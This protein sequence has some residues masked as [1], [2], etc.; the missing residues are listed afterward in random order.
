MIIRTLRTG[1]FQD[2]WSHFSYK[3]LENIF[4]KKMLDKTAKTK[5]VTYSSVESSNEKKHLHCRDWYLLKRGTTWNN[6]KRPTTSTKRPDTTYNDLERARN[7][8]KRVRHNLQWPEHSYNEQRKDAKRPTTS[9]FSDYFIIWSK[10]F[11]SPTRF[12][13][14]IWLQSFEHCFMEN[15]GENRAS[16]IYYYASRINYHAYCLRDIRFIFFCI[17]FVSAGKRRGYYFNSSLPLPPASQIVR[18]SVFVFI[19]EV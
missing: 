19:G 10:W 1:V 18:S 11:S 6:M 8:L 14:N 2:K 7:D 3:G 13:A 17:G 16:S 9:R 15:H 12:L 5:I 4:S